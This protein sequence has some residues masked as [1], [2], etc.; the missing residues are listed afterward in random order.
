M[1]LGAFRSAPNAEAHAS[2]IDLARK[3]GLETVAEASQVSRSGMHVGMGCDRGQGFRFGRP[4]SADRLGVSLTSRPYSLLNFHA[5]V[6]FFRILHR[7][8]PRQAPR[9]VA[10]NSRTI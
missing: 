7:I 2:L 9:H 6:T 3:I 5:P 4:V 8:F 1:D 10:E